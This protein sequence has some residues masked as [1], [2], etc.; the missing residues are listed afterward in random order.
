R[1][2]DR[3]GPG[4]LFAAVPEIDLG[5]LEVGGPGA[6][7][8]WVVTGAGPG[9]AEGLALDVEFSTDLEVTDGCGSRLDAGQTCEIGLTYTPQ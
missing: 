2:L 5:L 9:P 6:S 1:P 8:T 3:V 7:Y 4:T